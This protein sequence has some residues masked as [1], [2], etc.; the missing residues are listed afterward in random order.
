[1]DVVREIIDL[2]GMLEALI[3]VK[4][5]RI[6]VGGGDEETE[7]LEEAGILRLA[8]FLYAGGLA[9]EADFVAGGE[10]LC[11]DPAV[12]AGPDL[13]IGGELDAIAAG[14]AEL[15]AFLQELHATVA[16]EWE[17]R[18]M[19]LE[20]EVHRVRRRRERTPV[21][22]STEQTKKETA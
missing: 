5:G 11:L 19:A 7:E 22:T 12:M 14:S 9:G 21:I 4:G 1:M 6:A 18:F 8:D 3:E 10:V 20:T 17:R 16:S 15:E 13:V 2:L